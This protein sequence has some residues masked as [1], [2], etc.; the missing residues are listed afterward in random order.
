AFH[1]FLDVFRKSSAD[2]LPEHRHYDHKIT[3]QPGSTPTFGPIYS[4]TDGEH[5]SL[6]S[7]IDEMLDK[8][9]IRPSSSPAGS[10]VLFVPKSD[11]S[12]RLCVDYRSLNNITI[13]SKIDLRGAYNLLRIAS[14][15]EWKT[16]F[17]TRYGSF[18]YLVMPFGLCNA[19]STFQRFMNDV[20]R[21]LQG[22]SVV[23]YLDDILIF[24]ENPEDH[25]KHVQQVL[26]RLRSA[27]LYAKPEKCSFFQDSVE[28]LGYKI[29]GSGVEMVTEKVDAVLSWPEPKTVKDLQSFLGFANFYRRF[30]WQYSKVTS[31]L[32]ALLRKDT[33]WKW[34]PQC[35]EAFDTL[36]RAFTSAPILQ[37]F[38]PT[39][40]ITMETDASDYALAAV[41]S[42]PDDNDILH[43]V[44]FRSRKLTAAELNYEIH[45]KEML[46]I[47]DT[48]ESWRHLLMDSQHTVTIL[49]DHKNLEYFTT[50]KLLNRRQARWSIFIVDYDF[51]IIY[52]P[53]LLGG[54]PDA[55]TRR[56]DYHP[57]T[58]TKHYADNNPQNFK[59]LLPENRHNFSSTAQARSIY[60]VQADPELLDRFRQ[61]Y[62]QDPHLQDHRVDF[63]EVD[64]LLL[65]Q[66]RLY[67]PET[68]R[69]D[70]LKS[71]HDHPLAGHHGRRK[72]LDLV[73]RDFFWPH[74]RKF[75]HNYVDTCDS[76]AR[77]KPQR[78][79]PYGLLKPLSV[80]T[81]PWTDVTMDLIEALPASSGFDSILVIVERL[82]KM[83]IFIP[84][85]TT[86]TSQDL[87]KLYL[88]H[89]FAKHGLPS[90]IVSDR[91]SEFTSSFWRS[92]CK[93]L[94]IKQALSTA[95]HPQT[96]GQTE[97]VNQSL[98]QYL[99]N[100]T[101]YQ[102]SDWSDFLPL[103]EFAYNNSEHSTIKTT[104]FFANKGYHP[105][106]DLK[107]PT[108]EVVGHDNP[109]HPL[110]T[111]V[112]KQLSSVHS[113]CAEQISL[114]NERS[115]RAY[116]TKHMPPPDFTVGDMVML[117]SKNIKTKRPAGKLD[118]RFLGPFKI[119]DKISS[120]AYRLQLPASMKI[121]NVFHVSLLEPHKP[122]II[123]GRTQPPPLPVEVDGQAEYEVERVV[124][125]KID[126]RYTNPLRYLV[127]WSGYTGPDRFTWEPVDQLSCPDHIADFHLRYPDKPGPQV[128]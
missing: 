113:F 109:Y 95:Y 66:Q 71:R 90:T 46:A 101:N 105:S 59:T 123:V 89:V 13:F 76:C 50:S 54:K 19:P 68:L 14:G 17:R 5:K 34:T 116:D 44:A 98:E 107:A 27:H 110:A 60:T 111:S 1:D 73:R 28:F 84:T 42:Q 81:N 77:T 45:D 124:D 43:P 100:F 106:F 49:T 25:K 48:L 41:I 115:S 12:L 78:H 55:L 22:V 93:L 121:H 58:A 15:D 74:M 4:L 9:F 39:K 53:G 118:F 35:Q 65:H 40:S 83:S 64:G 63:Q 37:H 125:S 3:L 26:E 96:D 20:F 62:D 36:K 117:S 99:R 86:M 127:E 88:Q 103:A 29:S 16:A 10:P 82:T 38:D 32:T 6:R 120:H 23:I 104:P 61:A 94:G 80:P 31:P 114:T 67:V 8:G 69:V 57:G 79:K 56:P 126:R 72:T 102:Q 24:S 7:Y 119:L 91:G 75:I 87:A 33:S 51:R 11:G 108:A 30:I 92:L 122:N 2:K 70:V 52:R 85:Y 18:E 112:V 47:V 21:D 97:R 128:P